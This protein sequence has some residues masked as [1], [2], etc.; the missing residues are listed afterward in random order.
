MKMRINSKEVIYFLS[1]FVCLICLLIIT[2]TPCAA[3][4]ELAWDPNSESDLEG[5]KLYYGTSSKNYGVIIDVGLTATP[6][7]PSYTLTGLSEGETY[8]FAVTAYD[9]SDNESDYSNEVSKTIAIPDTSAPSVT[10]TQPTSGGTYSTS[11]STV[12]LQGTASD[13]VGVSKVDWENNR[14]GSGTATGKNDWTASSISLSEGAN[15]I[16]ITAKD[17]DGN[18][19]TDTLTITYSIPDTSA[20]SVTITQPTSDST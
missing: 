9:T 2:A 17:A 1:I 5:Y 4:V 20:P 6:S 8:Y 14:G 7:S 15:I 11:Q 12:T 10:I 19:G 3:E 16:T 18:Q 13:T